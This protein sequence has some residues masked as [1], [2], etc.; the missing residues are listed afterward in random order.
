MS[1][2]ALNPDELQKPFRKL[3]KILKKFP[4]KPSPDLVHDLRT[5]TRRVE[6]NLQALRLEANGRERRLLK[7]LK[8]IRKRAGKVRD[9]DVLCALAADLHG[10][11]DENCLI[12]LIE[13]LGAERQR[14]SRKLY[15]T[16]QKTRPK[17]QKL[18]K[19]S[20]KFVAKGLQ[21]SGDRSRNSQRWPADMLAQLL[22]I[23][24]E[25][26]A[27]PGLTSANL[28]PFRLKIKELRYILQLDRN[29]DPKFIDSLGEVKDA[30]GEW[31]DWVE[32]TAIAERL[33]DH[34]PE[35]KLLKLI[36]A[37][38]RE[39]FSHAVALAE[40]MR[41]KYLVPSNPKIVPQAA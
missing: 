9:M 36:R 4:R 32:L 27:W 31:H 21:R 10:E 23:E 34:G 33:L 8:P 24:D 12:E 38:A 13:H 18:L 15:S 25:L 20:S 6:A 2:V 5:R 1:L 3:A 37:N 7:T 30:I 28:H 41:R 35:C 19:A 11:A 29:A 39:K 16:V 14:K 40:K 26:R 22:G 17:A